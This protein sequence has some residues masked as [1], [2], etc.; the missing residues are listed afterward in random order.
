MNDLTTKKQKSARVQSKRNSEKAPLAYRNL[1]GSDVTD[2]LYKEIYERIILQRKYLDPNYSAKV[3]AKELN[4]NT[5]YLSAVINSK[6]GVNY[7]SLVNSHRVRDAMEML[8]DPK[9]ADLRVEDVGEYVGFSTR[10]CFYSAFKKFASE[11]PRQYRARYLSKKEA[12]RG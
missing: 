5:R 12:K 8:R 9:Y 7:S 6:F 4:T 10:Q 2:R 3:L 11:P 1:V